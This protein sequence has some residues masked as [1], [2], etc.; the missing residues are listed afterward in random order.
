MRNRFPTAAKRATIND[1]ASLAGVSKGTVSKYLA[2]GEY[3]VAKDTGAKIAA[4]I[5]KLD[6]RPNALARGLVRRRTQTIGVI[7]ASV[8]NPLYPELIMGVEE[9]LGRSGY[10]LLFGTTEGSAEREAAVL[11][12]MQQQQVDGIILASVLVQDD[13]V[14]QLVSAGMNVILA[15]R[16]LRSEDIVDG[17]IIDN[18]EGARLAVEHL[19]AH[20]HRRIGHVAGPQDIYPFEIRR[21]T[22]ESVVEQAKL[23]SDGLVAVSKSTGQEDGGRA[24]AELLALPEPPTAVFVASDNMAIGALELCAERGLRVPEDLAIVGFDN[25]RVGGLHGVQLTTV[26]SRARDIGRKAAERLVERIDER[27]KDG[28]RQPARLKVLQARLIRRGTCGCL[29]AP[30]G[31]NPAAP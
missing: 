11:Q 22:F 14:S 6:F 27:F 17:V 20:G 12:T 31:S 29:S 2:D 30:P 19:I 3:Y 23:K 8:T 15:S 1:V 13:E 28:T 18:A 7:V 4:A 26:D 5:E 21:A 25:I 9:V 24:L 16:H 10:T